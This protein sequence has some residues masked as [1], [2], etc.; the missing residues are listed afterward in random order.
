VSF[1]ILQYVPFGMFVLDREYRLVFWNRRMEEWTALAAAAIVGTDISAVSPAFEGNDYRSLLSSVFSGGAPVVF[2]AQLHP[3]LFPVKLPDGRPR[4][5]NTTVTAIPDE[6]NPGHF[7][8]LFVLEDVSELTEHLEDLKRTQKTADEETGLRLKIERKLREKSAEL[9]VKN[10]QLRDTN[11]SLLSQRQEI[12]RKNQSLEAVTKELE[13]K[14]RELETSSKYKSEFLAN[15]SHELRTPLNSLL[16]LAQNLARNK[17]RNL[18]M[19]QVEASHII[20]RSG[21]D[22]L[23]LINDIL[24]LSKIEAGKMTLEL[25]KLYVQD[26]I[27][28]IHFNFKHVFKKTGLTFHS[29]VTTDVPD[30]IITDRLRLEQIV[31]NLISNAVK[32]TNEGGVRVHIH[33]PENSVNLSHSGLRLNQCVAVTVKDTG[34]GIPEKKQQVIFEAFHQADGST[35]R[36]YGGTGLGLTISQELARLLGGEIQL[37]SVPGEGTAFTVYLPEEHGDYVP[38]AQK[39]PDEPAP[40]VAAVSKESETITEDSFDQAKKHTGPLFEGEIVLLVDDDMRNIFALARVLEEEG[41]RIIKAPNGKKAL[42]YL[43]GRYNIKV[44]LMDIMMPEMNGFE[45]LAKIREKE[46]YKS[47][48]VFALTAKAMERDREECLRAGFTDHI[49]KPVSLNTLLSVLRK[50]LHKQEQIV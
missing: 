9:A 28:S 33:R 24:D 7:A 8:A 6:K 19:E 40:M 34:I 10:E 30:T 36:K 50:I 4:M 11:R 13:K 3:G 43:D 48:P 39:K 12:S 23:A 31:K 15:M 21:N 38:P 41:L 25:E 22:L 2:S 49:P 44:V 1:E 42:E 46:K 45:T 17:D 27:E 47:L 32:F 37:H 5:Q 16:I 35:S 26:I 29:M 18:T 14:A 20:Y